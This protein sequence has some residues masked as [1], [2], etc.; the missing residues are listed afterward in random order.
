MIQSPKA[1]TNLPVRLNLENVDIRFE[2]VNSSTTVMIL[3][4]TPVV[5]DCGFEMKMP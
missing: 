1:L 3:G 2:G 5:T 4:A